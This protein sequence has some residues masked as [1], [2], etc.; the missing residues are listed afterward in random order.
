MASG[1]TL[2]EMLR[3]SFTRKMINVRNLKGTQKAMNEDKYN[4]LCFL[5]YIKEK[6][7]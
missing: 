3:A 1:P 2:W 6:Y 7:L 4:L 5:I